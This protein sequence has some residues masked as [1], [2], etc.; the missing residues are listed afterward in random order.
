MDDEDK[1][2]LIMLNETVLPEEAQDQRVNKESSEMSESE[3]LIANNTI[4]LAN[5]KIFF[6]DKLAMAKG[7]RVEIF[8]ET[9]K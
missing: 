5:I 2:S 3:E 7:E 6:S 9:G 4:R 1:I 8:C